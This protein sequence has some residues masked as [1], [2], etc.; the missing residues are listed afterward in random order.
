MKQN[1]FLYRASSRSFYD[2]FRGT[3]RYDRI[4]SEIDI[5]RLRGRCEGNLSEEVREVC[6]SR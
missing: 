1:L 4:V 5:D 3:N 6:V 2:P